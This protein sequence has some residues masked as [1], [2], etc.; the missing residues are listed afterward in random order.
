MV[1][2]AGDFATENA[3]TGPKVAPGV[4]QV[5]LSVGEQTVT[6]HFTVRADP[7]VD[8]GAEELQAQ[9]EL[10]MQIRDKIE[11]VHEAVNQL[12]HVRRQVAEWGDERRKQRIGT[13]W[14]SRCQIAGSH[15]RC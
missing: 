7:R 15:D 10:G 2:V 6:E 9:F 14:R 5:Q 8:V 11:Q 4:Y 13:D 12:R 1:K 3:T